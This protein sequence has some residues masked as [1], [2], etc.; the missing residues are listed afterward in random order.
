MGLVINIEQWPVSAAIT[1]ATEGV[2]ANY[3][4]E[5]TS[6]G[7]GTADRKICTMLDKGKLLAALDKLPKHLKGWLLVAHSAPGYLSDANAEEFYSAVLSEFIG[8]YGD[9][10]FTLS[11]SRW[12]SIIRI[13]PLI[14]Y[15]VAR[16]GNDP[17]IQFSTS[18][19]VAALVA[20]TDMK[21]ATVRMSWRRDWMP[22]VELIKEIIVGWDELAKGS[23]RK[24][25][26]AIYTA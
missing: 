21:P 12:E 19:Y 9:A 2:T 23:L 1:M 11:E 7:D 13:I 16:H 3:S 15:D 8:R 24:E 17:R 10:G 4:G 26:L 22:S 5:F 18:E 20:G 25:T 6:G 14:C